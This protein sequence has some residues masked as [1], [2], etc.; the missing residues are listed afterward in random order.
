[1]KNKTFTIVYVFG[2][3][4][5]KDK[6]MNNQILD[7]T[8]GEWVKIGE[9]AIDDKLENVTP[10]LMRKA[11]S[12]RCNQESTTGIPEL[13]CL[14]D[15]FLFP[16]RIKTDDQIRNLL[17]NDIY[18]L[19]NTYHSSRNLNEGEIAP[20]REFV[21]GASRNSIKHAVEAFDHDLI[22]NAPLVE[23]ADIR[24]LCIIN[25]ICID[26]NEEEDSESGST[27]N[28]Q[29]SRSPRRNLDQVLSIGDVVYLTDNGRTNV[30]DNEGNQIQATYQGNNVFECNGEFKRGSALAIK[31]I[32]LYG[33]DRNGEKRFTKS[34]NGNNCWT[35]N[36]KKLLELFSEE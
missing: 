13:S 31:Y 29:I 9:T 7:R 23:L 35:F 14:Y 11:A 4:R 25:S 8:I 16:Y 28:K 3:V 5:C 33:V 19:E 20:G 21:Y 34:E 15:V 30:I 22:V 24:E 17:C 12:K 2:P 26:D 1:M 27:P 32:N 6:Y 18:S 10:E 36:G